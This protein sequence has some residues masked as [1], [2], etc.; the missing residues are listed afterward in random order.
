MIDS[1]RRIRPIDST[2]V[3]I[4]GMS[5]GAAMAVN[6]ASLYPERFA[7]VMSHSGVA[8]GAATNVVAGLGAMA[9]GPEIR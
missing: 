7:G 2:R 9:L 8:V 1:V 5:A 6:I 3:Y 4:A